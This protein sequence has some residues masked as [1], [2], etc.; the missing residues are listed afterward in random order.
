MA[1]GQ[2][3]VSVFFTTEAI[4][5]R[6][7]AMTVKLLDS[8]RGVAA[9]LISENAFPRGAHYRSGDGDDL[10]RAPLH[11]IAQMGNPL[12]QHN[13]GWCTYECEG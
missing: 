11:T 7:D 3:F 13:S 8:Y 10:V 2:P 4:L 5:T 9:L 6:T 12:T 1:Q